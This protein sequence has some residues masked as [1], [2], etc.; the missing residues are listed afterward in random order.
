MHHSAGDT[1]RNE[2][3]LLKNPILMIAREPAWRV[4]DIIYDESSNIR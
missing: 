3:V 4:A 2:E 1:D